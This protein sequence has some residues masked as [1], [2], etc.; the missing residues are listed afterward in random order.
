MSPRDELLTIGRLGE[1]GAVLLYN[2]VRLVALSRGFPP[3]ENRQYWDETA[4]Q[5]VAHDFLQ[6]TRGPRRLLDIALRSVDDRSFER[7]LEAAVHNH[8][9]DEARKT[10]LGSL[11]VRLKDVL[12][13]S[14]QFVAVAGGSQERWALTGASTEQSLVTATVLARATVR[15]E[16]VIPRWS[17]ATRDAPLAD[18]DSIVR[19]I[20]AVL[21]AAGGSLT[22][23]DLAHALTARLDHRRAPLTIELDSA[24]PVSEPAAPDAD[25]S[26][27]VS[28]IRA[29]EIFNNLSD[30]ERI[31]VATLDLT[32]RDLGSLINTGK[33]QAAHLRQRLLDRV[34]GEFEDDDEPEQTVSVL[35][36]LC[37]DWLQRWTASTD[38]T[39]K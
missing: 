18:L 1:A 21:T 36:R 7:L 27:T 22:A 31:I 26:R 6:S 35:A 33:S 15:V 32:V 30:R 28:E 29:T 14:P 38:A 13:S 24:N 5:A 8:L 20:Q 4:V 17:S 37:D 12:R 25:P 3:P 11:I 34:A 39:F 10:D 9:R 2:T 19:L 23:V 16:V